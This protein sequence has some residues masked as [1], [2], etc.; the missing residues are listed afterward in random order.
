M[1][2]YEEIPD[3]GDVGVAGDEEADAFADVDEVMLFE[4]NKHTE[5]AKMSNKNNN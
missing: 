5:T 1:E 4:M 2:Q 3:F